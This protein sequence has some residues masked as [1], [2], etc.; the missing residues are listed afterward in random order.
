M[1]MRMVCNHLVAVIVIE[2]MSAGRPEHG[3]WVVLATKAVR[4]D[5]KVTIFDFNF[6]EVHR[7][8]LLDI[9]STSAFLCKLVWRRSEHHRRWLLV[10]PEIVGPCKE[11][12]LL[13]MT[14]TLFRPP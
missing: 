13:V 2:L 4:S 1:C 10:T 7:L 14:D 6:S 11:V 8:R 3:L 12:V 9:G 5:K